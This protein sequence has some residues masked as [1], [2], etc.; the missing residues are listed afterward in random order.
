M[1]PRFRPPLIS[2]RHLWLRPRPPPNLSTPARPPSH[3]TS[4][5]YGRPRISRP[6]CPRAIGLPPLCPPYLHGRRLHSLSLLAL[7]CTA[8]TGSR[9][10]ASRGSPC[11]T[12]R[13]ATHLPWRA[14]AF[15]LPCPR[16]ARTGS[17]EHPLLAHS[18]GAAAAPAQPVRHQARG[19]WLVAVAST[20]SSVPSDEVSSPQIRIPPPSSASP[21]SPARDPRVD[22]AQ[23]ASL[24]PPSPTH[25]GSPPTPT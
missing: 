4:I 10:T 14:T 20:S 15:T 11:H 12:R 7:P 17:A 5:S 16:H 9:S 18:L 21:P 6:P 8:S 1:R 19:E 3:P 23:S 24:A 25:A 13:P 2:P 22:V